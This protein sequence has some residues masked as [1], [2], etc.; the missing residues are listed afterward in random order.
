[1]NMATPSVVFKKPTFLQESNDEKSFN[2][3]DLKSVSSRVWA[4]G[5]RF[6]VEHE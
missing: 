2:F 5:D 3:V 6:E 1:M 4:A